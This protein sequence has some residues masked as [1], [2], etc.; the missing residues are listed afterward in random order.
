MREGTLG[1]FIIASLLIPGCAG[2]DGGA[3]SGTTAGS[4]TASM[5]GTTTGQNMPDT[6]NGSATDP[7]S[8]TTA[9]DTTADGDSGTTDG[10]ES[11]GTAGRAMPCRGMSFFATSE[12][13]GASGGDLGGLT[14]A[15][16]ACQNLADAVGQGD[17]TWHA[18][19]SSTTED[20]R[21]RIGPGP[22]QNAMGDVIAADV[23]SLHLDGLSNGKPQHVLDENGMEVPANEHDILTGS[24]EDGTFLRGATCAD[25]TVGDQS[26]GAGVGHSDIRQN[27]AFSPSWNAAHVVNGCRAQDLQSTN[28]GGRLYCFA[29]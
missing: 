8:T 6:D 2:D 22:W 9:A 14:G 5:T 26:D 12:G 23:A 19:L 11:S 24:Q 20:A 28:G 17:C 16:A 13:S 27:P 25:W 21:D 4:G 18:Y 7:G 10:Q 29:I 15:D 3:G 1:V